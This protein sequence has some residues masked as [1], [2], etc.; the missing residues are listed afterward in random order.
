MTRYQG[1]SRRKPSGGLYRPFRKP[2]KYELGRDYIPT[3]LSTTEIRRKI[4]V[5]GGNYKILLLRAAYANVSDPK[6]G[7]TKKVKVLRVVD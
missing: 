7:M 2:K 3:L 1:R 4:R 5:R 6:T